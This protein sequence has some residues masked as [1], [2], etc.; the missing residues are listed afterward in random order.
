MLDDVIRETWNG[1]EVDALEVYGDIFRLGEGQIQREGVESRDFKSNPIAYWKNDKDQK[2][3]YR[4]LFDDTFPEVLKEC[5]EADFC[6]V[7]GITYYGRKNLQSSAGKMY[8]LIFDL[9]GVTEK[10]LRALWSQCVNA[11]ILPLP[12]YLILSGHGVHL[13]YVMEDPV[14]LYPNIKIQTKAL[15]YA[16]TE[17]MWN[18]YVT[19]DWEK[20]QYQG[21]NQGFRVIG[22]KTKIDGVRVRAFRIH[23]TPYTLTQLSQYAPEE[24][25]VDESKLW[26][27]T[28]MS[29]QEAKEKYPEWYEKRVKNKEGKG[30]WTTKRDLYDWWIRKIREG[31]QFHH[32]YFDIMCL[33]IYAV[34]A[35][36]D[37]DE[38]KEDAIKLIPFMNSIAPEEPFTESDVES[39]LECYD[40]R[41]ITFPRDD[42]SKLSG[43]ALHANK[44]NGRKQTDH[45][46]LMNFVRDE[47]NHNTDWRNKEGRPIKRDEVIQWR[48]KH[49]EGRKADCIRETGMDRKTVS[50]YWD[51]II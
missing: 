50:K 41:Y 17:K 45:I 43:I 28:R 37:E 4:I 2:G 48:S 42:I 35:G 6:I 40:E 5:Q 29:L 18:K 51:E 19:D 7:N 31:A 36:I 13:Y 25:R 23:S 24:S 33:A 30:H 8:A 3:H 47:L 11:E 1:E 38:L 22:G 27:E 20:V 12:N 26:K 15:K 46:R 21:I 34:K 9:D 49:P 44:R 14:P 39:A 10:G 32:R 16:L